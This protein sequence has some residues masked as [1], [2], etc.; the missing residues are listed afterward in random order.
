MEPDFPSNSRHPQRTS[1]TT[2]PTPGRE[3]EKKVQ[4]VVPGQ[5]TRRKMSRGRRMTQN[6]LG[7]DVQ[8]IWGWMFGDVLIP[9]A[10]DM[11]ADALTGGIER[12]I[13]GENTGPTRSRSRG[14]STGG[15]VPYNMLSSRGTT[16][17]EEPRRD[18]GRRSRQS[19]TLDE[20]LIPT[21]VA[22]DEVLNRLDYYCEQ[23]GHV[24]VADYYELCGISGNWTDDK[25]GWTDVRDAYVSRTR[26]GDYIVN[27][28]KPESLD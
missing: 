9:A 16:R 22:A 20:V 6:L 26:G 18:Q 27:L 4:R 1:P 13:F 17:R 10:R 19:H 7:D 12:A 11:I 14:R 28:P 8:N 25:W 5:V 15:P 2:T 3:E 23:Y 24:S 21:R